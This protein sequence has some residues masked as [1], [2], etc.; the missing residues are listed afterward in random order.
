MT[1]SVGH[2]LKIYRLRKAMMDDGITNPS[3]AGHE[4]ITRLVTRLASLDPLLPCELL[5]VTDSSGSALYRFVV[6]DEEIASIALDPDV[7]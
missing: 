7:L 4:L 1:L 6:S 2:Y 3:A 5:K